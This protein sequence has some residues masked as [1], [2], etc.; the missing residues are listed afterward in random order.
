MGSDICVIISSVILTNAFRLNQINGKIQVLNLCDY[1][2]SLLN[3][4]DL[5][6]KLMSKPTSSL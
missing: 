4:N 3:V 2:T 5:L 1:R 6:P